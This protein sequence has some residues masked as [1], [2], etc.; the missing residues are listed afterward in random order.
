MTI[1]EHVAQLRADTEVHYNCCQ[2]VL[3][4]FCEEC[5]IDRDTAFR[6]GKNFNN[7]MKMGS[8]CGALAGAMM[9]LGL[10]GADGDKAKRLREE[11][12]ARHEV[13]DC[14]AL[15]QKAREAGIPRKTHCDGMVFE[16]VELL[17]QLLNREEPA[18][19]L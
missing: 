19:G 13:V 2:S 1:Q 9:V 4:P 10:A 18:E 14:T 16:A 3:I 8:A 11:F 12:K 6:L 7:G 15:L 5:G 17:E